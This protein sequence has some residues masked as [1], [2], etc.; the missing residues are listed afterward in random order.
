MPN[1]WQV[2][3]LFYIVGASS[4]RTFGLHCLHSYTGYT[5][6]INLII[7]N[8][9]LFYPSFGFGACLKLG[10]AYCSNDWLSAWSMVAF[11][12]GPPGCHNDF[13]RL[14][15]RFK[16][17]LSNDLF[18]PQTG[19]ANYPSSSCVGIQPFSKDPMTSCQASLLLT[20]SLILSFFIEPIFSC[21]QHLGI[22]QNSHTCYCILEDVD[23][24]FMQN[25]KIHL[26]IFNIQWNIFTCCV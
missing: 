4:V 22:V 13:G 24:H 7:I 21:L 1:L 8:Y 18:R 2:A 6:L 9:S 12:L 3:F 17:L 19:N 5:G 11:T 25:S 26:L 16:K 14:S 10:L 23:F 15:A 20:L